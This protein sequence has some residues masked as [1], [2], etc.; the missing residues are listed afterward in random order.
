MLGIHF[1]G[2]LRDIGRHP[3]KSSSKDD[4]DLARSSRENGLRSSSNNSINKLHQTATS[5]AAERA[6][7]VPPTAQVSLKNSLNNS[8]G[9]TTTGDSGAFNLS[10]AGLTS[11]TGYQGYPS[12]PYMDP[13]MIQAFMMQGIFSNPMTAMP[14][15][16]TFTQT[17]SNTPAG[18]PFF[19]NQHDISN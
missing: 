15:N 18:N 3:A 2:K 10:S 14:N 7:N 6:L 16:Y 8:A 4:S 1:E 19:S 17:T 11:S 9:G 12:I 13:V 5:N